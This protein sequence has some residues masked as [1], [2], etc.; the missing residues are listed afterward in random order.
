MSH[1]LPPEIHDLIVDFLHDERVALNAC[2]LVSKS[3]VP[4]ARSHLFTHIELGAHLSR[5]SQWTTTFPDP[6]NSPGHYARSLTI[7][8]SLT[9]TPLFV[10]WIQAFSS[11]VHLHLDMDRG[12]YL[13]TPFHGLSRTLKSLRL[14]YRISI[15]PSEIFSFVCSFP[16]LEDL[17]LAPLCDTTTAHEWN[18]PPTSPKFTGTLNV[19]TPYGIDSVVRCLVE[20]PDGLRFTSIEL[21]FDSGGTESVTN[22]LSKCSETLES[23]KMCCLVT[24]KPPSLASAIGQRL[25]TTCGHSPG[26][27][28][29]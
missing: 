4:R 28:F 13:L 8:G 16:L 11:V 25:T 3:W 14:V 18:V 21:F 26:H 29:D 15:P 22:L 5:V 1:P 23:L 24:R 7:H 10:N 19:R 12:P 2:C 20:L 9:T 17:S 6:S 27:T